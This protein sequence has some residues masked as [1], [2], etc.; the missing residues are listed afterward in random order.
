MTALPEVIKTFKKHDII[1]AI[2][3]IDAEGFDRKN[4]SRNWDLKYN[5]K[6]Y[7]PKEVIRVTLKINNISDPGFYG[8]DPTNGFLTNLGFKVINKNNGK[9][10]EKGKIE[11]M[12]AIEFSK[13]SPNPQNQ[14]NNV[15]AFI[16]WSIQNPDGYTLNCYQTPIIEY[17]FLHRMKCRHINRFLIEGEA[18]KLVLN[19]YKKICSSHISSI[20]DW[21]KQNISEEA[22]SSIHACI[23]CKPY[24]PDIPNDPQIELYSTQRLLQNKKQIILFGPPGTGKT[25]STKKIAVD[26]IDLENYSS[27]EVE[28]KFPELKNLGRIEFLTFHPSY[29]YEEFIEGITVDL[30]NKGEYILKNGIFKKM[31]TKAL[32]AALGDEEPDLKIRTAWSDTYKKYIER[33]ETVTDLWNSA[34]KFVVIIDEIN[35]GDPAKIFGE[36]ITLLEE[37]KRLGQDNEL[38]AQLPYSNDQF[39]IPPNI[40]IIGTMNTADRSIALIDIALR[41]RFGFIEMLPDFVPL[42]EKIELKYNGQNR[43]KIIQ[44][45]DAIKKINERICATPTLG[46]DKLIGHSFFYKLLGDGDIDQTLDLIWK[47]EILPLLEEYCYGRYDEINGVLFGENFG[48]IDVKIDA[49]GIDPSRD[50]LAL[51]ES[52]LDSD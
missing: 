21:I 37:D 2:E 48:A 24:S 51:V 40:Y 43:E 46:K 25:Y 26:C 32:A 42:L 31:C 44:S 3:R 30:E 7:P 29:S 52:I 39:A 45:I 34:P 18:K 41:R 47:F 19:K 9:V 14:E 36:L 35:R 33:K 50:V 13:I 10:W 20:E 49:M 38:E 27:E 15:D 11:E 8:G 6:F 22:V 17:L 28:E 23:T 16:E 5:G 4:V 12:D 1:N